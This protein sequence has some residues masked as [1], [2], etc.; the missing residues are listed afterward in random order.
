MVPFVTARPASACPRDSMNAFE[1]LPS[2]TKRRFRFSEMNNSKELM[3]S[4]A[5]ALV[6]VAVQEQRQLKG[7]RASI[8][9]KQCEHS[10]SAAYTEA[11]IMVW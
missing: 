8:R 3:E 9:C 5:Q 2:A 10:V 6:G 11:S 4:R 7:V 1:L